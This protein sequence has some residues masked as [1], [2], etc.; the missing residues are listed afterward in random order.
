MAPKAQRFEESIEILP[1]VHT[2]NRYYWEAAQRGELALLQC[3]TCEEIR[4]PPGPGC[5]HCA[6]ED[7]EWINFGS[8][9]TGTVYTYIIIHQS[10]LPGYAG[11]VP[12]IVAACDIDLAP[13]ARVLANLQDVDVADVHIGMPVEMI[14]EKR[15]HGEFSVPQWVPRHGGMED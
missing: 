11:I 9:I 8:T 1:Q 7:L 13:G 14:W 6:A 12:Y 5:P 2:D 4:H 15:S 3:Q 10:F